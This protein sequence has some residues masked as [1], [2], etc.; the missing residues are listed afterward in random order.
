M[1]SLVHTLL[2]NALAATVMAVVAVG[3][4]GSAGGPR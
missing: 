3:L 1:E 2:S 4:A